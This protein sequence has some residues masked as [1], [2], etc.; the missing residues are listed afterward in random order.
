MEPMDIWHWWTTYPHD[1]T[2][3]IIYGYPNECQ[4]QAPS[5]W[6]FPYDVKYTYECMRRGTF[7]GCPPNVKGKDGW[8]LGLE[9]QHLD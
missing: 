1:H 4:C 9:R 3:G 6:F 8:S 7:G 2:C 5:N